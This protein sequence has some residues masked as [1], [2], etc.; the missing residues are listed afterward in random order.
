MLKYK[1]QILDW[2]IQRKEY[3]SFL[4]LIWIENIYVCNTQTNMIH[5]CDTQFAIGYHIIPKVFEVSW[6]LF[7]QIEVQQT[8]L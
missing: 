4:L 2:T 1:K 6:L 8:S 5:L 3:Y 7:Y